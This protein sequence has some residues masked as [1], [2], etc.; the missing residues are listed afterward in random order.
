LNGPSH[1]DS[2][3]QTAAVEMARSGQFLGIVRRR[4][5]RTCQWIGCEREGVFFKKEELKLTRRIW[6]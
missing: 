6:L 3:V 4:I 2:W 1:I 5:Q